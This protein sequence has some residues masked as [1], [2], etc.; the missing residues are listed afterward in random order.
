MA[1]M[2][3]QI[4]IIY[5]RKLKKTRRKMFCQTKHMEQDFAKTHLALTKTNCLSKYTLSVQK[6]WCL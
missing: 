2:L 1:I 6:L 3:L 4:H 5:W